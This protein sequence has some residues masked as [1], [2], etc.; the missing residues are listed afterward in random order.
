MKHSIPVA[1]LA[2]LLLIGC[3][4][5]GDEPVLYVVRLDMGADTVR[6][7]FDG[8]V[9]GDPIVL[10]VGQARVINAKMLLPDGTPDPV[11][12]PAAYEL[13]ITPV[14]S[15]VEYTPSASFIGSIIASDTDTTTVNVEVVAKDDG[16]RV[17]GAVE[18]DLHARE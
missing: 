13:R 15:A 10:T 11:V 14:G 12:T 7:K 16:E 3:S 4:P 8:D 6:V 5:V 2:A 17:F 9:N 18:V 1:T